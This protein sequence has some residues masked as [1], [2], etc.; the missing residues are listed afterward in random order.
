MP[1]SAID[2]TIFRNVFG[3]ERVRQVWSDEYRTQKYL[4]FEGAL[5]RA[6]ASI[7]LIP[8]EAATEMTRVCKVENMDFNRLEQE[9]L[10]VGYP[11]FASSLTSTI[12]IARSPKPQAHQHANHDR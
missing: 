6:Q 8:Q 5:A 3:D 9:T 1:A 11:P 4:D 7:G 10:E 2:S 12:T